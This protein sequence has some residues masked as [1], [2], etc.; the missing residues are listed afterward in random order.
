MDKIITLGIE[1]TAHTLGIG[2][3]IN[4]RVLSDV[5]KIY[6]PEKGGIIP[7]EA[8][9]NHAKN[10]K[11][12][13]K[14]ALEIADLNIN[15]IDL[16]AFSQGP[17][18]PPC[19]DI[20]CVMARTLHMKLKKPMIGVNHALAHIEIGK[21]V[22]KAKDPVVLYVSG[23]NS[24]II[25]LANG[26]YRIFGE[27]LDIAIGNALDKFARIMGIK[28]P[29]GPEIEKMAEKGKNLIEL[30]YIVKGMDFSFSGLVTLLERKYKEGYSKEDLCYSF[31][32]YAFSMLV[33]A[34]ERA[35]AFLDKNE[36][37][38]VGGVAANKRLCEMFEIMCRE[39]GAKFYPVDIKYS[40]DNGVMIAYTGYL[41][42]KNGLKT[43]IEESEKRPNWRIDEVD[44][45][46]H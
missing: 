29:G 9:E 39:R 13:I 2:I 6:K 35:L 36:V 37:L 34:T 8:S 44:V 24:Q 28:H 42:H 45:K 33:E 17:G 11:N 26:R 3:T 22:T 21:L 14:E 25:S 18:M 16:I 43:K 41:M 19:L 20:A 32:E 7:S 31:Q 12:A 40:G 30:P 23:G 10:A 46:W 4:D 15:D 5:R 1:S 38:L 27:T